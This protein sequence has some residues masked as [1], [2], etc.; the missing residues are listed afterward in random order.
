MLYKS[1]AEDYPVQLDHTIALVVLFD[2]FSIVEETSDGLGYI[3]R[4]PGKSY[5]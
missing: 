5:S 4:A 1:N 2:D 3:L